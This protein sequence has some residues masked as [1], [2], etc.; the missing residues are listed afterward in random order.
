MRSLAAGA[1]HELFIFNNLQ[2]YLSYARRDGVAPE[3][4]T[5][6]ARLNREHDFVVGKNG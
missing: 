1:L 4:G 6:L 2:G 5:V 3:R